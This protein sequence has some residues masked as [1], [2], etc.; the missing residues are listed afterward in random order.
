MTILMV[1]CLLG[2]LFV[3]IEL[4]APGFGI[5]GI[6]GTII[7][8]VVGV[9]AVAYFDLGIMFFVTT[10]VLCALMGYIFYLMFKKFGLEK[11]IVLEENLDEK[12]ETQLKVKIGDEGVALTDLKNFGN[13]KFNSNIEEVFSPTEYIERGNKIVITE[14]ENNKIIVNKL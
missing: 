11:Y 4:F 13:A 3:S 7:F 14:I 12:L 10:L 1:L 5:F 9:L 6:L 2:T 8:V